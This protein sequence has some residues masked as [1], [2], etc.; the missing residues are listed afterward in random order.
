[1]QEFENSG[2]ID[3]NVTH[4]EQLKEIYDLSVSVNHVLEQ[5]RETLSRH[6][7]LLPREIF[8]SLA[9]ISNSLRYVTQGFSEQEQELERLYA[10]VDV[11]KV[12]NSSLDLTTVLNEV[13]D[14]IISLTGAERGFLMLSNL[15]G[16]LDFRVARNMARET[17]DEEEFKISSTIAHRV[18]AQGE[19]VLTTNAQED[20][21]F[22]GQHS[23]AIYNLRSILCV[24]LKVKGN[25]TGLIYA[26]NRIR[27]GAFTQRDLNILTAFANQAAVALENARLFNDLQRSNFELAQ[28]Y[29]ITL[30]GWARALELRDQETEGH[31]RRVT[32]L[33]VRLAKAMGY[34]GEE[35]NHIR[36][37]ALLHDIGKMGIPDRILLK[38]GKLTDEE[39]KIMKRH[40]VYAYE[41]LYPIEKL[42]PAL[43]IPHRHHEKWDGSG[44]PDGLRG[45]EIP[46]AARIFAIVD[47]WDAL[48][49]DRPYREAWPAERVRIHVREQSNTH[50]DPRVVEAFLELDLGELG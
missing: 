50:F 20:P 47:V 45:K 33:T 26:D 35:L 2:L 4:L 40:P 22:T 11:S 24:P 30:E 7:I 34:E 3:K 16:T 14:T 25:V 29:D 27:S 21:R 38:P 48:R 36:R 8:H 28:T 12:I 37:G 31:T 17:L 5:Q 32:E 6:G 1:M 10:L 9:R 19:P 18:A 41:M 42:R 46:L 23:V 13:M 15:N 39:Q 44:Y 43:D 49:S